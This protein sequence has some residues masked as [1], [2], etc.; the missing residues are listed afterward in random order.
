MIRAAAYAR[1]STNRQDDRSIEDQ[2]R[3]CRERKVDY[4]R[5]Q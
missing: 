2:Q 3:N 5:Q 4:L 1:Y